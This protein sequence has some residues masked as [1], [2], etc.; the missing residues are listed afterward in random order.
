MPA[1]L[2]VGESPKG[3]LNNRGETHL[4]PAKNAK[5]KSTCTPKT[6]TQHSHDPGG[7][8]GPPKQHSRRPSS[9]VRLARGIDAPSGEVRL[10]RG[11]YAPSGGV[12]LAR[13]LSPAPRTRS[14]S[15]EGRAPPRAGSAP[16][17]GTNVR[18]SRVLAR[19]CS[20]TRVQAFNALTQQGRATTLTRLGITPRRCSA[21]SRGRPSPPLFSTVRQGQC[22]LRDT[23]PPALVRLTRRALEEGLAI[24][25][26]IFY[27]LMQDHAVTSGRRDRSSP[28]LSALCSH[29]R[30]C[31]TTPDAVATSQHCWDV[32]GQ[33]IATTA[34][35]SRT[36]FPSTAPSSWPTMAAGQP[37]TAPQPSKLLLYKQRM[38]QDAPVPAPQHYSPYRYTYRI[39]ARACKEGQP[40]S[41]GTRDTGRQTATT[42]SLSAFSTILALASIKSLG[43]GGHAS[44]PASLVATPLRAP[45]CDQYSAPST[46]LLDVRPRP[47]AG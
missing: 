34:I 45:R 11:P 12:R 9:E 2:V 3:P 15:L 27:V 7:P 16:L 8:R 22:Q 40:P 33:D 38:H 1:N 39:S 20:R 29:P 43:L 46:P 21:N 32:R 37:T 13:G 31:R 4:K 17:E 14:A 28:S 41:R 30:H 6:Y 44:S 19:T 26:N 35:V 25:S 18:L 24:L 47:E 5:C 42:H 36:D 10:A 23:E